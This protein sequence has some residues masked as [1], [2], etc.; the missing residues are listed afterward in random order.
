[1][2]EILAILVTGLVVGLLA[3]MVTPRSGPRLGCAGTIA[4]GVL[5]SVVGGYLGRALLDIEPAG[6]AQVLLAILGAVLVLLL[7]EVLFARRR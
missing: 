4:V 6:V 7:L 3:R 2:G 1:M 5:G